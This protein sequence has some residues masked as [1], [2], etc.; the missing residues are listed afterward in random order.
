MI[1]KQDHLVEKLHLLIYHQ[2]LSLERNQHLVD[3]QIRN[4]F[5]TLYIMLINV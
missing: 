3:Q 2:L 5:V 1:A 4:Y